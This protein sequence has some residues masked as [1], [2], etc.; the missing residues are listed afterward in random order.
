[1]ITATS[2]TSFIVLVIIIA[3][4]AT[5]VFIVIIPV[6]TIIPTGSCAIWIVCWWLK[7][8]NTAGFL[9][10]PIKLSHKLIHQIFGPF[11]LFMLVPVSF[12]LGLLAAARNR[13]WI[14]GTVACV[15]T[16]G[17]L[18]IINVVFVT[19]FI[20]WLPLLFRFFVIIWPFSLGLMVDWLLLGLTYIQNGHFRWLLL[21]GLL[22]L[23][24]RTSSV[25]CLLLLWLWFLFGIDLSINYWL[26]WL[27]LPTLFLVFL[28]LVL[29]LLFNLL[30]LLVFLF[31]L[32][33]FKLLAYQIN[34]VS[35]QLKNIALNY[36]LLQASGLSGGWCCLSAWLR[37][38]FDILL[39]RGLMAWTT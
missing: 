22:L 38:L 2:L 9:S 27:F 18:L 11:L 21:R 39:R 35:C 36:R 20:L 32:F 24:I 16:L 4:L 34:H 26:V 29:L 7:V 14:S 8:T 23:I 15:H 17:F 28:N 12:W 6:L 1:M 10:L 25:I 31:L 3:S 19:S 33:G 13:R 30:L 5:L 37:F